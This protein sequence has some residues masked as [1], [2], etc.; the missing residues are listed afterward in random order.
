M[1]KTK[2]QLEQEIIELNSQLKTAQEGLETANRVSSKEDA[3]KELHE[4]YQAYVT[5]GFTDEQAWELVKILML[6]GTKPK[7]TLF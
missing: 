7:T 3:G 1:A 6:N 2:A 4:M 5:A